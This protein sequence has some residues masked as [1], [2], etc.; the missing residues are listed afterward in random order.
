VNTA[1][2]ESRH[3]AIVRQ[4]ALALAGSETLADAAPQMIRAVCEALDWEYGG[5]WEV[6]GPGTALRLVG[7]WPGS[8]DRFAEFV[9]LS[10][11]TGLAR[12]VGLP[13]RVWA[14]EQPAWIPDVVVDDNFPRAAAAER[15]GLHSAFAFPVLRGTQVVGVME[16]FS[17]DIREPDTA[18]LDT[19]KAAGSQ[20]GLYAAG[21]WAADEL[22]AFFILSPDLLCVTSA[23]GYF[24]R[25]NPA[26]TQV[27][28]FTS[29]ELQAA[30]F[31]DFVHPDDRDASV[32]A[33]AR[34]NAGDRIINFENRYRTR[35]GSYRWFDWTAAPAPDR[36]V[37]YAAARDITERKQA[38]ETLRQSAEDLKRLVGE[39]ETERKKAES[40][41]AAKGEFLANMSHE[42]RT[43]MNAII[44]M[45]GL[46]LRTRLD[47]SQRE[48]IRTA[49]ESAEALLG[50]L[51]DVLDVSKVE[52]GRL[53]LESIP[54]SL[55]ESVEGAVRLFALRAHEKGLE[56]ACRI[57]ADVPDGLIGDPGRLRQVLVNLVGNAVK[58][59]DAG[60]VVVEVSADNVTAGSA[61]LRFTISDTGIGIPLDKQ[62]Q[63]FGA[64]VQADTSTTRRFGGTGL[65]LTI[66]AH[67]VEMMGGRIWLTS[68]PGQGSRFRFVARF[69][70]Q[71]ESAAAPAPAELVDGLRVLVVDDNATN[72]TVL[73]E[74]LVSWRMHAEV[75]GGAAA[76]LT[77]LRDAA[78][79]QRPFDLVLADAVMPE[80][81]GLTLAREIANDGTL[82]A[83][84]VIVLTPADAPSRNPRGLRKTIVSQLAKPVKQ[85]DLMDAILNTFTRSKPEPGKRAIRSNAPVAG[86]QRLRVLLADD[87]RTNQR[88]VELFLG[89]EHHEVTTVSSG[90]DAV[91]RASGQPFDLILMDV[92]MPEMD[93]FEAT[94]A[95]RERERGMGLHTPIVAMTAHAMAG[96]REKCLAA[97]MDAYLSKPLRPDDLAATIGRLFPA[98]RTSR[99]PVSNISQPPTIASTLISEAE[100]L[101]DFG[102]NG[103]VLAEVIGVFLVD[104]PKYLDVIRRTSVSNG[105]MDDVEMA[106]AVHALKGS[107]GLFSGA[108][109]DVVRTLEQAIKTGNSAAVEA[110][111]E[112]VESVLARLSAELE[113]I[114]R[115]LVSG[116][117]TRGSGP[118]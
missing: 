15:V 111:R 57:T 84:K 21:K 43:P 45:T 28:G 37:I 48:Y 71:Q 113:T 103:K 50:I 77:K 58:F 51:N 20:I 39:L 65:G 80:A 96:D 59:T 66:S 92:Q 76:A 13:G 47:P 117:G 46:A 104:A 110:G 5:L 61:A 91:A 30:P 106:A 78:A 102:Q 83:A 62:W 68:E 9:E 24:L 27:L 40:A 42:I 52:A 86:S 89:S 54:F 67:L 44:G 31:V 2:S 73:Q 3:A 90:R 88:L 74:L 101:A 26:W 108:A 94:A 7:T 107:V 25:L 60:D 1:T 97:G 56:L 33:L 70:I 93:G 10:R 11:K 49:N 19:M 82:S 22:D 63:I 118:G 14:S 72:R 12:G 35:D 4:I 75:A 115:K 38:D 99:P 81:D 17:R 36:G 87:N 8:S 64:F 34:A 55:R 116:L 98:R 41:S 114:R 69:G 79:R 100:L 32:G 23:E 109:C 6:D 112:S 53:V 95:I 105:P 85:S 16:F 18:L 29:A